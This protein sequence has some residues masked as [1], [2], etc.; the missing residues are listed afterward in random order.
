[1][2]GFATLQTFFQEAN[3]RE[4]RVIICKGE[5]HHKQQSETCKNHRQQVRER[6]E[7]IAKMTT[8]LLSSHEG[9]NRKYEPETC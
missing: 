4:G 1:M 9:L 6:K 8:E 7:R 2:V 5:S 3:G